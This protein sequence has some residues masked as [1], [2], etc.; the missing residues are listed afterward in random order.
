MRGEEA[1]GERALPSPAGVPHW[2]CQARAED[3]ER[4]ATRRTRLRGTWAVREADTRAVG[5]ESRP[6]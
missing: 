3:P 5:T 6:Q 4:T 1:R 2:A